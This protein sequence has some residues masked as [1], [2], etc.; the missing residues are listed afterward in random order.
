MNNVIEALETNEW[1]TQR[2]LQ[3]V[4]DK[5]YLGF[6]VTVRSLTSWGGDRIH[7]HGSP[8]ETLAGGLSKDEAIEFVNKELEHPQVL[9]FRMYGHYPPSRDGLK[10]RDFVKPHLSNRVIDRLAKEGV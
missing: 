5:T 6:S 2:P 4:I 10:V 8:L 9:G 7:W 3:L 1:A